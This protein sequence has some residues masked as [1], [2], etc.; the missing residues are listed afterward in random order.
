MNVKKKYALV[1]FGMYS[2]KYGQF[3][4]YNVAFAKTATENNIIP[5]YIYNE[6]P[7]SNKYIEDLK[8]LHVELHV[9]NPNISFFSKL[10]MIRKLIKQYK[11]S[12]VHTHFRSSVIRPVLFVSYLMRVRNRFNTFHCRIPV[13]K[14]AT[15]LSMKAIHFLSTQLFSVSDA[16]RNQQIE[17]MN[18]P[19]HKIETL[20]LGIDKKSFTNFS[21]TREQIRKKYNLPKTGLI[22]CNVAFH[23]NEKGIDVLL[24]AMKIVNT[25]LKEKVFLCQIGQELV[26][27]NGEIG[28]SYT[29]FLKSKAA[30]L[31]I[32]NEVFWLGRQNNVPEILHAVDMYVHPSRDEGLGLILLEA[33][34]S[35][36]PIIT[37]NVGGM[38][39]VVDNEKGFLFKSEDTEDLANKLLL[40]INSEELRQT[41][42]K[43]GFSFVDKFY[44]MEHQIEKMVNYYL[45]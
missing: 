2:T 37:S 28:T 16:I 44:N 11:P 29:N 23:H 34:L 13:N 15:K 10:K 9:L 33:L 27:E 38:P 17:M 7:K 25:T 12:V 3:E 14:L 41:K 5:V 22:I 45:K 36:L 18:A 31:D 6:T 19:S 39:E 26:K 32:Q 35:K 1:F 8:A 43:K 21:L 40:Y 24:E 20:R 42:S 30:D 4:R